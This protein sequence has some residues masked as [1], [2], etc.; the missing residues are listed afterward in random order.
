M[1]YTPLISVIIPIY[2]VELYL[3]QCL[4]SVLNQSYK[5]IELILVNDG[6]TDSSPQICE[7][8]ALNDSRIVVI[9]QENC[10][11]SSARNY[12][13]RLSSGDYI[14]YVD[15]DDYWRGEGNLLNI[16]QIIND[17]NADVVCFGAI[18]QYNNGTEIEP[19]ESPKIIGRSKLDILSYLI[20]NAKFEVSA[21]SKVIK[22][23]VIVENNIKFEI[24]LVSA[25]DI[26]WNFSIFMCA[27]TLAIYDRPF[28]IYRQG[29]IG[30]VTTSL[31]VANYGDLLHVIKKWRVYF[32]NSTLYRDERELYLGYLAYQLGVLIGLLSSVDYGI[33]TQFLKEIS[34][35]TD[36]LKYSNNH[37]SRKVASLYKFLGLEL[38]CKVLGLYVRLRAKGYK[39]I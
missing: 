17:T 35:C 19:T 30:S 2:N 33:R 22:R 12:G 15:S 6:S 36:I 10:G 28:Y 1:I 4:D 8:Y 16:V 26:D 11:V 13:T 5:H 3:A 14:I 7:N 18:L 9:H 39:Y 29:R 38:T 32:L 24:G 23:D 34:E 20:K 21:W 25:E 37:K 27:E 31:S